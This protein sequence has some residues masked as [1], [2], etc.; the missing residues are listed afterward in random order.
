MAYPLLGELIL[1]VGIKGFFLVGLLAT[2][3]STLDSFSFLSGVTLGRDFIWR[4]RGS[5]SDQSKIILFTRWGLIVSL[6]LSVVIAI[7]FQSVIDIW[8]VLGS[9]AIPVL[10]LPIWTSFFPKLRLGA[11]STFRMMVM[12]SITSIIWLLIGYVNAAS[13]QPVY[14]LGIEPM[15]P[16]LVV[17][18]GWW[19]TGFVRNK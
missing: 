11:K 18:L 3:M 10:L 2:I 16:G 1:P 4:L 12:T 19:L 8:Y 17:S 9:V 7:S 14:I 15:Y 6:V 5:L 13:G